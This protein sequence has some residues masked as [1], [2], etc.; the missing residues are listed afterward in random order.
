MVRQISDNEL[1]KEPN[2]I[3]T[4]KDYKDICFYKTIIKLLYLISIK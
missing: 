1:N 3:A 4:I 2:A